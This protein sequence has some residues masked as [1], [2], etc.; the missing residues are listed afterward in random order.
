[1]SWLSRM[2]VQPLSLAARSERASCSTVPPMKPSGDLAVDQLFAWK[3]EREA[4]V[5]IILAGVIAQDIGTSDRR[6]D[7]ETER[8]F[9][10]ARKLIGEISGSYSEL[11]AY[12]QLLCVQ[13]ADQLRA[14]WASV[15]AVAAA[16]LARKSLGAGEVAAIIAA[17]QPETR[18]TR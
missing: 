4:V 3:E 8:D 1:M 10:K 13:T 2:E 9:Q 7:Y 11:V 5:R 14:N 6:S 15:D 12:L 18:S 17:A 16:L